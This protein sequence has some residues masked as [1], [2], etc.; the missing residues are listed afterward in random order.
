MSSFT[1]G[2]SSTS[3]FFDLAVF[4]CF[5]YTWQHNIEFVVRLTQGLS[6]TDALYQDYSEYTYR[7]RY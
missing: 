4:T 5:H 6:A 1:K 3:H 2:W 7:I